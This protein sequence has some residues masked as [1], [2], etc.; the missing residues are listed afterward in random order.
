MI[1]KS[2]AKLEK[3]LPENDINLVYDM[4]RIAHKKLSKNLKN[5][6]DGEDLFGMI[7]VE[8]EKIVKLTTTKE[9]A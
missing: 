7:L 8:E 4:M 2:V 1:N 6:F 9:S 3:V 5:Y